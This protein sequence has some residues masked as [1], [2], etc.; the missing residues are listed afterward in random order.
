[1]PAPHSRTLAVAAAAA[2]LLPMGCA[3]ENPRMIPQ[4]DADALVASLEEV[5]TAVSEGECARATEELAAARSQVD[6]LPRTVA[7]SLTGR[8]R[9]GLDHV[10]SR[11]PVDCGPDEPEE[12]ATPTVTPEETP[13][14]EPTGTPAETPTAT[15]DASP[16]P[17]V[18]PGGDEGVGDGEDAP[19]G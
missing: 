8:L 6:R 1:M 7:E 11:I 15:P 12:T 9:Q 14:P 3:Q 19:S 13:P 16:T 10:G 5:A 18:E 17:S 2:A 4:D